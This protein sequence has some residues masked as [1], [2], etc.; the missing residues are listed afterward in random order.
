MLVL[1]EFARYSIFQDSCYKKGVRLIRKDQR[2]KH[3]RNGDAKSLAEYEYFFLPSYSTLAKRGTHK[4]VGAKI[5]AYFPKMIG[6]EV[7]YI[8]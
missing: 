8:A 2:S 7:Y 5:R 1:K 3:T 6:D 4:K